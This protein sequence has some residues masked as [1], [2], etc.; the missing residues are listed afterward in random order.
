[1]VINEVVPRLPSRPRTKPLSTIVIHSTAGASAESSIRVLRQRGLSYHAIG[2]R[3]G[4]IFKCVNLSRVAFHAGESKGPNGMNVNE[5]SLGYS[6][7]NLNNGIDP[8][9]R[10]QVEA[11]GEWVLAVI[12]AYP[13]IKYI[14]SHRLISWK[15]KIDPRGFDFL[16]FCKQFPTL[17]PWRQSA[18]HPWSLLS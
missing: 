17:K 5:Y 2:D 8:Y 4:A 14:T 11:F 18:K 10:P 7:A 13:S 15:R 1:M 12:E 3:D 9:T 16:E 6:F